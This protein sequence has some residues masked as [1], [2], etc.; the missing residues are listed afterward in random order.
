[1]TYYRLYCR[2]NGNYMGTGYN[3]TSKEELFGHYASYKSND[4]DED[5]QLAHWN[6]RMTDGEKWD[7]ILDDEF[8]IEESDTLFEELN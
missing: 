4:W 5:E 2:Q 8:D 7:F 3:T 6:E 1:M